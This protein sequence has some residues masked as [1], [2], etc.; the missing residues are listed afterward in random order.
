MLVTAE[1]NNSICL[2]TGLSTFCFFIAGPHEHLLNYRLKQLWPSLEL[3]LTMKK[4]LF[5][6]S[7]ASSS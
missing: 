3:V 4:K 7:T 1:K 6:Y 5:I 2:S